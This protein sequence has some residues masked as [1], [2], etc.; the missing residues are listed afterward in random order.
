MCSGYGMARGSSV[1]IVAGPMTACAS[2]PYSFVL[3]DLHT[4]THML[5]DRRWVPKLM[6]MGRHTTKER[7]VAAMDD[8]GWMTLMTDFIQY[9][10]EE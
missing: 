3:P 5:A 9:S 4:P 1:G 2:L 6:D 10:P 8:D 7:F